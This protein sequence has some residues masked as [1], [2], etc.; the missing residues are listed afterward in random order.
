MT[1]VS[2]KW[3]WLRENDEAVQKA[4]KKNGYN[5]KY[6]LGYTPLLDYLRVIFPNIADNDWILNKKCPRI[7]IDD[8]SRIIKPDFRNEELKIV[9]EVDGLLHYKNEQEVFR[10]KKKDSA[11]INAGYKV[12]RI[13]YFIQLTNLAVKTLFG[14]DVKEPLFNAAIPSIAKRWKNSP[15]FLCTKGIERMARDFIRFPDQYEVNL[16]NLDGEDY[17]LLKSAYDNALSHISI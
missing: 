12:V 9:I 10:D 14:V 3:G 17:T 7:V 8:Q 6:E 4:L 11:Y 5:K 2:K 1:N 13:P 15:T 16:A